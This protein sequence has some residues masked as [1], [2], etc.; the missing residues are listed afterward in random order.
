[1]KESELSPFVKK[2]L[3]DLKSKKKIIV[4]LAPSFV[5]DFKYPDIVL[6]LKRLGFDKVC[7]LTFGAK[8]INRYYH[9]IIKENLY[10]MFISS[11]CP[12][13]VAMIKSK[14]PQYIDNIIPVVSPM[15]ATA[16][17]LNK[18]YPRHELLFIAPCVAKREEAKTYG[19]LID[20]VITFSELKQLLEYAKEHKL[21]KKKKT[22]SHLFDKFYADLTKIYP[23][24]GGLTET[25]NKHNTLK[26]DEIIIAEGLEKLSKLFRKNIPKKIRFLDI[27]FC[28]GG[29]I[30]GPGVASTEPIKKRY[31][32][33]MKYIKLAKAEKSGTRIG[34]IKDTTGVKFN[35][36]K[37][38]IG[39]KYYKECE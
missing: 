16:R 22:T 35:T 23:L 4:M 5:A 31:D 9:G 25:L 7:E 15:A 10:K 36:P 14:Y 2:V 1:M 19:E 34:L 24:S 29:C 6:D 28:V 26:K 18:H 39:N 27:L 17:I 12:V 38:Y 20:N 11:T 32:R 37:N 30:G 21:F 13:I 8:M 33:V 3:D